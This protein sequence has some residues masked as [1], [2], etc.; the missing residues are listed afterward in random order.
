MPN[1]TLLSRDPQVNPQQRSTRVEWKAIKVNLSRQEIIGAVKAKKKDDREAFLEKMP[2][3]TS[4]EYLDSI[5]E[6]RA[7][8][9]AGRVKAHG[10][11]TA[12]AQPAFVSRII[13][14]NMRN[15]RPIRNSSV[16]IA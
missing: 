2:V 14:C 15:R 9:R 7:D 12:S 13:L 5:R 16:I 10:S 1:K 3:R 6:A 11:K 4:P 8:D